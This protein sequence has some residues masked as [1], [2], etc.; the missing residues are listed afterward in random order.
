MDNK[1]TLKTSSEYMEALKKMK[2]NIIKDRLLEKPF[3]DPDIQKGM[4]VIC[5]SYDCALDPKQKEIMTAG[6]HLSGKITNRYNVI[7]RTKDDLKNRIKMIYN[8]SKEVVC[9]QRCVGGDALWALFIGTHKLDKSNN[10]KTDYHQRLLKYLR[11]VQDND[12]APTAAVTDAKGDRSQLPFQQAE[13]DVYVHMVKKTDQGIYVSGIKIPITMSLYA[14][15]IIVMPGLQLTENDR[16][17][18]VAF[19][20]PAD[21]EGVER[22]VLGPQIK[23]L[24]GEHAPSHG[25]RYLNKEGMIVFNNVFVPNERI[26][27]CGEHRFGATFA[28]LFAT[29]HRFSY[30]GCK[31]ALF[32]I[33]TGAAMLISEFNGTKGE[34]FLSNTNEKILEIAKASILIRGMSKATIDAAEIDDSGAIFPDPVFANMGKFTSS[35]LFPKTV[36]ILQ[37]MAGGLPPNLPY[38]NLLKDKTYGDK[39]NKL[40]VR[41]KGITSEQHYKLNEFIRVLVASTEGGLLQFGSKHGGGNKE[42]EKVAIYANNLRWMF[43]CKNMVKKMVLDDK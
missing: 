23:T 40:F 18:A 9:A 26:F 12:I 7:P 19:A 35:E 22:Y 20:I 37:D 6:S 10:H 3:E 32:D 13:K 15:E 8:L 33:M 14:E 38:E 21:T 24:K 36:S 42:A 29:L 34:Y 25:R 5:Y 28:N 2:P 43:Q 41:S 39:V 1:T 11:F 27:L 16:D 31:P 30:T 17:F 4:N